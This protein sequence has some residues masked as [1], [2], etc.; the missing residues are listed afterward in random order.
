MSDIVMLQDFFQL[1]VAE[2]RTSITYQDSW[3][4]E[5]REYVLLTK[6]DDCLSIICGRGNNFHPFADIVHN[7]Q[8]ILL[9][10]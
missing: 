10:K 6:L 5:S 7:Q 8:D 3:D 9:R 4:T 1:S 2:V